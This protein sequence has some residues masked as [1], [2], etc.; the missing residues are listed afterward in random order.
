M[1]NT[2]VIPARRLGHPRPGVLGRL[3][4][5]VET[6]RQRS[7]LSTLEARMLSDI[8]V[9]PSDARREAARWFWDI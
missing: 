1:T 3:R 6:S 5:S 4:A 9:T 8:G 2:D 7:V